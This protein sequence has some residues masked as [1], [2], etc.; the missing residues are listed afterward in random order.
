MFERFTERARRALF[1]ARYEAST[2]GSRQI[3]TEHLLLGV[4]RERKGLTARVLGAVA[5]LND[6]NP[7]FSGKF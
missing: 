1:F 6:H 5:G 7:V 4:V 3:G 2:L